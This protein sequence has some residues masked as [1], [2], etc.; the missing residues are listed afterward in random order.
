[1]IG[2]FLVGGRAEAQV[3]P[4]TVE[5]AKVNVQKLATGYRASKVI[6]TSVTNRRA[7]HA[8]CPAPPPMQDEPW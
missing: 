7:A 8:G 2:V 6:G 4:Q 5:L 3:A 1:M